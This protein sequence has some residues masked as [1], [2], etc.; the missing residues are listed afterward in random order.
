M[1]DFLIKSGILLL[2]FYAVYKL[3]LENEKMFHF[4]RAYL[5]A[6]LVFSLIIPL[7]IFSFRTAFSEK[8]GLVQLNEL[9]IQKGNENLKAI[10]E[11]NMIYGFVFAIYGLVVLLLTIRFVSN[12]LSFYRKMKRNE[13]QLVNGERVVLIPKSILPY[14]FWNAI[15]VDKNE[16]EN[17]KIPSELIAHEKAHLQQR[18]TLDILFLEILQ[19]VFWFNPLIIFY[20]KA[21]KLNHEF[22]ADEAVNNKFNSIS[23]YQN[24]LLHIASNKDTIA[25]ASNINYL[26]TKKRLLMMSK[27]ESPI[28]IVLKVFSVGVVYA[29]LLFA[30]SPKT[31]AQS[32]QVLPKFSKE[33]AVNH[34]TK[35][36]KEPK[37]PGGIEQF[38]K[39][40]GQNFKVPVTPA[41]VKLKGRV[42]ITFVIEKDGALSNFKMLRDI[43]YGTG[44]EAI[45]VLKLC[46]NWIP[47]KV[48]GEPVATM[49]SLPITIQSP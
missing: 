8:V 39:F 31:M 16:F 13:R 9:V 26:I 19:I 4:N 2:I 14:S 43:G 28:K 40:I 12:L 45:R 36:V 32:E 33:F 11:N 47:G 27:K 18:H 30:F 41:D 49:Y 22:L 34:V 20:K 23:H 10:S 6:S 25:L 38:Y 21:V 5:L 1:I 48:N 3:W 29:L 42:Y 35:N 24:L 37:F 17:G 46:P 44:E 15:F 7:Q